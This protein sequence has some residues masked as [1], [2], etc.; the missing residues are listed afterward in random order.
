MDE[1]GFEKLIPRERPEECHPA[2]CEKACMEPTLECYKYRVDK[3]RSIL[4]EFEYSWGQCWHMLAAQD[5]KD[6]LPIEATT[7][8][9]QDIVLMLREACKILRGDFN[10]V[11][12]QRFERES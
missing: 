6:T 12:M 2:Q 4:G 3:L 1:Y 8:T 11:D 5:Q 10:E 7:D 9:V